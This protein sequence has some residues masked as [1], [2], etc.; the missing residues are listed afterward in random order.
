MAKQHE[1]KTVS[2]VHVGD[3]LVRMDDLDAELRRKIATRLKITYLNALFRGK[4]T[5]YC[6]DEKDCFPGCTTVE[7]PHKDKRPRE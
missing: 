5:F 2:Y 3:K 6:E 1:I 7:C 4:A